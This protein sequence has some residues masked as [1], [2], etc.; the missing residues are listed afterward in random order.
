[1]SK[2]KWR[3]FGQPSATKQAAKE[4]PVNKKI[5][6]IT[7][8]AGVFVMTLF[9]IGLAAV[10]GLSY[11]EAVADVA[12]QEAEKT[13]AQPVQVALSKN[14]SASKSPLITAPRGVEEGNKV[15]AQ[16]SGAS[17][18]GAVYDPM[19]RIVKIV[20]TTSGTVTSTKQ[21]VWV[22]DQLCEERD[23]SGAVTKRFFNGG[24]QIA[25][26]N[27][28]ATRDQ[29]G[30]VRELTNGAGAIQSQYGYG[31]WGEVTKLAGSG[32]D[33]DM[34]YAGMYK[35]Q[36]S[37]LNLAV[38]R[39]YSPT[40]GRWISRDP[41]LEETFGMTPQSPEPLDPS[42]RL[43]ASAGQPGVPNPNLL[44]IQGASSDP[45]VLAQLARIIPVRQ[46]TSL[47]NSNNPY[48]YVENNPISRNDPSGLIASSGS[49]AAPS[50]PSMC[51]SGPSY[52]FCKAYCLRIC[53][54]AMNPSDCYDKCIIRCMGGGK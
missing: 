21:F 11:T 7:V 32:P 6:R 22:G 3:W 25:G 23:G 18:G 48:S 31:P 49:G 19:R 42:V 9:F 17:S 28:Y 27:Y 50:N 20:E 54:N 13:H 33:S 4:T 43:M 37:G 47:T 8:C 24:E 26:T 14:L 29:L 45:M 39:A 36:R 51:P 1:M 41:M 2:S 52:E 46:N 35:H 5:G 44:A 15:I 10:A 16:G 53:A 38:N 40:Q 34:Q 12:K 30:S